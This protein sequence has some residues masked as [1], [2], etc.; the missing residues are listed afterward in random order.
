[1]KST[2]FSFVRVLWLPDRLLRSEIRERRQMELLEERHR[3]KEE[4]PRTLE[5]TKRL[6]HVDDRLRINDLAV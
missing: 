3:L 4:T 1:M 5:V 2:D 6:C